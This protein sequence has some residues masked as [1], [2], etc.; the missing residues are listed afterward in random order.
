MPSIAAARGTIDDIVMPHA[1]R[2]R[3]ADKFTQSAR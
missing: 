3:L 1:T 2:K